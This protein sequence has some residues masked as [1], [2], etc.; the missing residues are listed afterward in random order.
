[1]ALSMRLK[2]H[3][4]FTWPGDGPGNRK[5]NEGGSI[6]DR[7]RAVSGENGSSLA[8][9]D[10]EAGGLWGKPASIHYPPPPVPDAALRVHR[11]T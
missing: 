8:I 3:R 11:C 10:D 9:F 4:R 7:R 1:M 2:A 6:T 5:F